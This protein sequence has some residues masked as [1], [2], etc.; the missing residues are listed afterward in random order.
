[1]IAAADLHVH[2]DAALPVELAVGAGT[3]L[4]VAGW[5]HCPRA[6]IRALSLVVDGEGRPV[7]AHGMPRLDVFRALHPGPIR[8][9]RRRWRPI[10]TPRRVLAR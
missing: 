3:A 9:P 10:R 6:W 2:L 5:C 7:S 8:T 1:V 4:F